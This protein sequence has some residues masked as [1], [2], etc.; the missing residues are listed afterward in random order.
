MLLEFWSGSCWYLFR[1]LAGAGTG[2]LVA[3]GYYDAGCSG[4]WNAGFELFGLV[5]GVLGAGVLVSAGN[6]MAK[7][8]EIWRVGSGVIMSQDHSF[9]HEML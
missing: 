2:I 4:V 6:G 1:V 8:A 5:S 3:F 9:W 7:I